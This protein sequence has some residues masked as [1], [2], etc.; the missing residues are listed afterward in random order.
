MAAVSKKKISLVTTF[1]PDEEPEEE[2]VLA[3]LLRAGGKTRSKDVTFGKRSGRL[4]YFP[5]LGPVRAGPYN[6]L[7]TGMM[8]DPLCSISTPIFGTV[9]IDWG[10]SMWRECI[11]IN[12][13]Q[14]VTG[15][16]LDRLQEE[17]NEV[18]YGRVI[19]LHDG[20]NKPWLVFLEPSEDKAQHQRDLVMAK[21]RFG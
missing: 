12:T 20:D 6:E 16:L 9:R 2:Y 11:R 17:T 13:D 15:E 21:M 1:H 19:T 18:I 4:W 14:E 3:T 5:P 8:N 7:A 10:K